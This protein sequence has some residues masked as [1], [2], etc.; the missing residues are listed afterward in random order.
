MSLKISQLTSGNPAQ[1][2]DLFPIDRAGANF[3]LSVGSIAASTLSNGVT[4]S[5]EVALA[6]TPTLITPVIGAATGTSLALSNPISSATPATNRTVDAEPS[7][8]AAS[9]APSGSIVG[10]RGNVTISATTTLT[11]GYVY[12]AQ[13]KVTLQ[14]VVNSSTQPVP[15]CG[16]IGQLD[17]SSVSAVTTTGYVVPGWFDCGATMGASVTPGNV[18]I[19]ML[20]NTTT[21]LIHAALHVVA[22]ASYFADI[23]DL[24]YGGAHFL[25]TSA[26]AGTV[27]QRLKV[28][29]PSGDLYI[30]LHSAS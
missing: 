19:L 10:V 30:N 8:T 18:D 20:T 22:D 12:G 4:G 6:N 24:S 11:A 16:I 26:T 17:L 21:K 1:S 29:T 15:A 23:T 3:S 28:K 2:G 13:G 7:L 9:V 25:I 27:T 5:G 14:G